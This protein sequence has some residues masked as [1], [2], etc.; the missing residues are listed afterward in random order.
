MIFTLIYVSKKK[1]HA[2]RFSLFPRRTSR[3]FATVFPNVPFRS[4]WKDKKIKVEIHL[5]FSVEIAFHRCFFFVCFCQF[6]TSMCN[7]V[8]IEVGA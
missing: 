4:P 1:K 8:G 5:E 6:H 2:E 7:F 3:R